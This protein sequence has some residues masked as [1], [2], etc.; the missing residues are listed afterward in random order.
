M[1]FTLAENLGKS[2]AE[3]RSWPDAEVEAW[4]AFYAARKELNDAKE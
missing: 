4:F 1:Q 3:V 2:L